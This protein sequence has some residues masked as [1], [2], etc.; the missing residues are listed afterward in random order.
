MYG[1]NTIKNMALVGYESLVVLSAITGCTE[2]R[3]KAITMLCKQSLPCW[4]GPENDYHLSGAGPLTL[5]NSPKGHPL[6]STHVAALQALM[7]ICHLAGNHLDGKE[8]EDVFFSCWYFVLDCFDQLDASLSQPK[9]KTNASASPGHLGQQFQHPFFGDHDTTPDRPPTV[10]EEELAQLKQC[11][12]RFPSYT[13]TLELR[14]LST[15]TMALNTLSLNSLAFEA[16]LLPSERKLTPEPA[17]PPKPQGIGDLLKPN[18]RGLAPKKAPPPETTPAFSPAAQVYPGASTVVFP[19]TLRCLV[20]LAMSNVSRLDSIWDMTVG[21]LRLVANNKAPAL[22]TFAV[23]AFRDLVIFALSSLA[24]SNLSQ[25]VST[26]VRRLS[27]GVK[28]TGEASQED[29]L[30][31][32]TLYY[33]KRSSSG[34]SQ[35]P[36]TTRLP[37]PL[38]FTIMPPNTKEGSAEPKLSPIKEQHSAKG[39]QTALL[40]GLR[41]FARSPFPETQGQVLSALNEVLESCGQLLGNTGAWEE[42]FLLL[43]DV[44]K[45]NCAQ[46]YAQNRKH[47]GSGDALD[48]PEQTINWGGPCLVLSFKSLRLIV[49][50]FLDSVDGCFLPQLV[51]CMGTFGKQTAD[52]NIAFTAVGMLWSVSDFAATRVP[53]DEKRPE[54]ASHMWMNMFQELRELSTDYRPEVRNCAINTL[55][56]MVVANGH[57]F[58]VSEW[59]HH[60]S[61][62]IFP[63]LEDIE[64][65]TGQASDDA[66]TAVAPMVK[67]GVKLR[68]HHSRDTDRKQWNETLVLALQGL[69][70]LL[71][72]G[73]PWL[74]PMPWFRPQWKVCL[75]AGLTA[76]LQGAGPGT[77][78]S[79]VSAASA[80]LALLVT[81]CQ[82]CMRN[83]VANIGG[84][85]A[86]AGMQVVD[87]A[88]QL[89]GHGASKEEDNAGFCESSSAEFEAV[90]PLL[91]LEAWESFR[92]ATK[93]SVD[94]EGLMTDQLVEVL[95]FLYRRDK[96][97]EFSDPNRACELLAVLD[98]LFEP[99]LGTA[100][101]GSLKKWRPK[102]T[103]YQKKI[104]ALMKEID[105]FQ[106]DVYKK[107]LAILA[108][109]SLPQDASLTPEFAGEALAALSSLYRSQSSLETPPSNAER[110]R[111]FV[112]LVKVSSEPFVQGESAGP[113]TVLKQK[114]GVNVSVASTCSVVQLLTEISGSGLD[115]LHTL[116]DL[117][118]IAEGWESLVEALSS[119]LL[120]WP[121]SEY[122]KNQS[123]VTSGTPEK[124]NNS[125]T[126]DDAEGPDDFSSC[127][128]ELLS[129]V[130]AKARENL[131][132]AKTDADVAAAAK[133]KIVLKLVHDLGRCT[134]VLTQTFL[135]RGWHSSVAGGECKIIR[136]CV[137]GLL[138]LLAWLQFP[139]A[140]QR[141]LWSLLSVVITTCYY[142][143]KL[144]KY[145]TI[146]PDSQVAT[147]DRITTTQDETL[148][149]AAHRERLEAFTLYILEILNSLQHSEGCVPSQGFIRKIAG[150]VE[151][152]MHR[153]N[154]VRSDET[155]LSGMLDPIGASGVFLCDNKGFS[156]KEASDNRIVVIVLSPLLCNCI[157]SPLE[158][159]RMLAAILLR[160]ANIART[161]LQLHNELAA[162]QSE[163]EQLR[164]RIN[165]IDA[166]GNKDSSPSNPGPSKSWF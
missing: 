153:G 41:E 155:I 133:E 148:V 17:P 50:D 97:E 60:L 79:S 138:G 29:L 1:S 42:V 162:V 117:D 26:R 141:V 103:G 66:D 12:E 122:H 95:A 72:W 127:C 114:A 144:E 38:T 124:D 116:E 21:H 99:R 3:D 32:P 130:L 158:R 24:P 9:A 85:K 15:I 37:I 69:E 22:R 68:V 129:L 76:A 89:V 63:L 107:A 164:K 118:Q 146:S 142:L 100:E 149:E 98:S 119:F 33:R 16:T 128:S 25:K 109:R 40:N 160:N 126:L 77:V 20:E 44:A 54:W 125:H 36:S 161:V 123:A 108:K 86:E 110:A 34:I 57:S 134:L 62:L 121:S 75:L 135:V 74:G 53:K 59:E 96:T 56:S 136:S 70:R 4:H 58:D 132:S 163:N 157:L 23:D 46:A 131:E 8:P 45:H 81:M 143:P 113:Q 145:L 39:M 106:S 47:S 48:M 151:D 71:R 14:A 152:L 137:S 78:R 31:L 43:S 49:D 91:F 159:V 7:R 6:G 52:V 101:E 104:L 154:A 147:P 120:F 82:L 94:D 18:L 2:G 51:M 27:V 87:G 65:L 90:R 105:P 84:K 140:R 80:G 112:Q 10:S 61:G 13:A 73:T 28:H 35:M 55:F 93:F 165:E 88:L 30:Q 5:E 115:V 166:R 11:L 150:V 102:V 139:E 92:E 83:G 19:F 64:T 111:A 67:K 156:K